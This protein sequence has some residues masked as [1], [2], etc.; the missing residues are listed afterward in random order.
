MCD[1]LGSLEVHNSTDF[2]PPVVSDKATYSYL[3]GEQQEIKL[4][5]KKQFF[6][7]NLKDFNTRK[8]FSVICYYTAD[9]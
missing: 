8:I 4:L 2:C 6:T 5:S 9:I 7:D 1:D 3:L